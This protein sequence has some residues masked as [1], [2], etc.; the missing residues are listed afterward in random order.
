[1]ATRF[2]TCAALIIA[3]G[4]LA[5]A[6]TT[7]ANGGA[8]ACGPFTTDMASAY[9]A[10][11]D[12]ALRATQ[13]TDSAWTFH[14]GTP[15]GPLLTGIPGGGAYTAGFWGSVA[16]AYNI[17]TGGPIYS[18]NPQLNQI[19]FYYRTPSFTGVFLHPGEGDGLEGCASLNI[20]A[21]IFVTAI[22]GKFEKLGTWDGALCRVVKRV[23]GVDTDVV[24]PTFAAP[25]P[26]AAVDLVPISGSLPLALNPGDTLWVQTQRFGNANEDW[27]NVNV[28]VTFEG[29]PLVPAAATVTP[30]CFGRSAKLRI[31]AL[32]TG[33]TYQWRRNGINVTNL[34]NRYAG[35]TT[36]EL[37]ISNLTKPDTLD[38]YDCAVTS[39]C[40]GFT[41]VSGAGRVTNLL[42]DLNADGLI[43][44]ADL[45]TFLGRFGTT[46]SPLNP[47][48]INSDGV[49][50]TADL[51]GFLGAFGRPCP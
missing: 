40:T 23:A 27:C 46:V 30:A 12:P 13:D 7:P 38:V 49:V 21:P 18:D 2:R 11:G 32:G 41:V 50:N 14:Q 51:V 4:G 39:S 26:S 19:G 47:A 37:T 45:T 10:S 31:E 8:V 29:G 22:T 3:S 9:L 43:N 6:F 15:G 5:I 42:P 48:D 1:M 16:F 33:L 20:Q 35:A 25:H 28:S 34:V 24:A 36:N 17:P 44:T